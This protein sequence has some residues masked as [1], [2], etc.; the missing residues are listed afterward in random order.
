MTN[1]IC[2]KYYEEKVHFSVGTVQLKIKAGRF[3]Q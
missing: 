3:G 2:E 1:Y